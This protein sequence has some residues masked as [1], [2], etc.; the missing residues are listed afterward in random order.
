MQTEKTVLTALD[1]DAKATIRLAVDGTTA[2]SAAGACYLTAEEGTDTTIIETFTK[3]SEQAGSLAY[4]TM[5]QA[6]KDSR[7]RLVQV[8]MQDEEQT[9]LND[10]GCVCNEN[11]KFDILQ[12]FIGKG[13]H[14]QRLHWRN[15]CI[16]AQIH[17]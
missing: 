8:F 15:W 13:D 3:K 6:K 2:G 11:A 16:V 1:K 17:L 14:Q 9:L 4:R 12:I 5:I 10:I 7:V